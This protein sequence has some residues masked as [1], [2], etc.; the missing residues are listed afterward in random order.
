MLLLKQIFVLYLP[1]D[2]IG[3][4]VTSIDETGG[5]VVL[6]IK[7]DRPVG[8]RFLSIT[9]P[10]EFLPTISLCGN[11]YDVELHVFWQNRISQ[12]P[13]FSIVSKT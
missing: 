10:T 12:A 9:D 13:V 11:G 2:T 4:Q 7:N 3:V 8:T 6:F 5:S 1:G